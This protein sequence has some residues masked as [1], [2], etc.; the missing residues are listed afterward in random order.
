MITNLIFNTCYLISNLYFMQVWNI[1]CLLKVNV[2]SGDSVIKSMAMRMK[3]K[4]DMYC[5]DYS[6]V[7]ALGAVLDPRMKLGMIKYLS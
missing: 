3:I 5:S 4:F 6:V 2:E 7:L 1:E